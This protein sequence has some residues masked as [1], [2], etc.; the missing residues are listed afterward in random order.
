MYLFIK[1]YCLFHYFFIS[2]STATSRNVPTL[3]GKCSTRSHTK[4]INHTAHLGGSRNLI[5]SK[6]KSILTSGMFHSHT[7]SL[8]KARLLKWFI[9]VISSHYSLYFLRQTTVSVWVGASVRVCV[10]SINNNKK[11]TPKTI[12]HSIATVKTQRLQRWTGNIHG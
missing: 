12:E 5:V 9:N 1:H 3:L 8:F 7:Y 11:I 10:F 2:L 4:G 6:S